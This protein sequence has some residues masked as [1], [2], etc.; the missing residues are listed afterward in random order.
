MK[1]R[2]GVCLSHEGDI[3][4]ALE[5]VFYPDFHGLGRQQYGPSRFLLC[6]LQRAAAL[7][8]CNVST[9]ILKK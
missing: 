3:L 5:S 4:S 8:E 2:V 6:S 9:A 7:F 1:L